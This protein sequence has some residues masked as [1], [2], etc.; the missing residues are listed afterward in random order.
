MMNLDLQSSKALDVD[1]TWYELYDE[2]EY[3]QKKTTMYHIKMTGRIWP[4][5]KD[6]Q[7]NMD[8]ANSWNYPTN[9]TLYGGCNGLAN[10]DSLKIVDAFY[11][12]TEEL[13]ALVENLRWLRKSGW[14]QH[15]NKEEGDY[16]TN[17]QWEKYQ[18]IHKQPNYVTPR[19]VISGIND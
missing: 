7:E 18:T 14:K 4:F 12:K 8:I 5:V 9:L 1:H 3:F 19:P 15:W 2:T 13:L 10:V 11:N 6:S 17:D 16:W